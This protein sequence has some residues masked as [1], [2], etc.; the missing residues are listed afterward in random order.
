MSPPS[1][2]LPP[3]S[4]SAAED[5]AQPGGRLF[6]LRFE[7]PVGC[8]RFRTGEDRRESFEDLF[9]PLQSDIGPFNEDERAV[10]GESEGPRFP[11]SHALAPHDVVFVERVEEGTLSRRHA[12]NAIHAV[13]LRRR[14]IKNCSIFGAKG[15]EREDQEECADDEDPQADERVD[16]PR[17]DDPGHGERCPEHEEER[18]RA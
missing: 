8:F 3:D 14:R 15:R 18:T 9:G 10:A 2:P 16:H 1:R 11:R 5:E 6:V 17:D 7:G 12:E 13:G 4:D